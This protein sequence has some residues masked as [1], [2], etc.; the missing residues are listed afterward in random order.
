MPAAG[1]VVSVLAPL[2]GI[3]LAWLA[4][5]AVAPLPAEALLPAALGTLLVT[6]LGAWLIARFELFAEVRV[7]VVGGP[8]PARE[9][10]RE[11]D[12]VAGGYR[13][14]GW[15]DRGEGSPSGGIRRLGELSEL[16]A[17]VGRERLHLIVDG[18]G[19]HAA[20]GVADACVGL[21]VRLIGLN[22]LY[23]DL[24]GHV[25]V[26]TVDAAFFQYLMHP[27]YRGG[28]PRL[29]RGGDLALAGAA[30]I[31]LAPAVGLAALALRLAG[32][33]A[34]VRARRVGAGGVEFDLLRLRAGNGPFGRLLRRSRLESAPTLWNVV[35]GEMS[36]VGPRAA[37]PG[38]VAELEWELPFYDRRELIK[39]GLAGWAQLRSAPGDRLH[40]SWALCHDLYYLKHRSISL[41]AMILLQ[42]VVTAGHGLRLQAPTAEEAL[43]QAN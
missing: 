11:L 38:L 3:G 32:R 43:A 10:A 25:P 17:I 31:A 23:E 35:R 30:A 27:N 13:V 34:F 2:A 28:R 12:A 14:V 21:D 15:I 1:L 9:L 18:A 36:L 19:E 42:T 26:A 24:V 4:C 7:A 33:P 37:R 41:D 6:A 40:S 8:G 16:A 22:R 20:A 5:F 39:P 29:K